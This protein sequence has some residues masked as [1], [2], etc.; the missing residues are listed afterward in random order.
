MISCRVND[1]KQRP[2]NMQRYKYKKP[3][4]SVDFKIWSMNSTKR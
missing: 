1:P 2:K 3:E 4:A